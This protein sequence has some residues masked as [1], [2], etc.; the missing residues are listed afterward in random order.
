VDR[1]VDLWVRRGQEEGGMPFIESVWELDDQERAALAA[2]G[3]VELRVWHTLTPPVSLAVGPSLEQR[4][5][6]AKP[7]PKPD[8]G[9]IHG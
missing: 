1:D 4:K 9:R 7:R 5:A 6:D 3:T 2:G 8:G